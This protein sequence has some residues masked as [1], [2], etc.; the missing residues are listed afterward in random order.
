MEK[1][2]IITQVKGKGLMIGVD[3][4]IDPKIIV[5]RALDEKLLIINAG[6]NTIRLVPA[7]NVTYKEIDA[8]LYV[9]EKTVR[10]AEK[11]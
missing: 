10:N 5:K 9:F 11:L 4:A 7:L 6:V 3:F 8:F 1:S 2:S